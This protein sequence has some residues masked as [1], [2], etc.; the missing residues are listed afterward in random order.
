MVAISTDQDSGV[1]NFAEATAELRKEHNWTS[2]RVL[3][4]KV[5]D[6]KQPLSSMGLVDKRLFSGENRLHAKLDGVTTLWYFQYDNGGLP[7]ALKDQR[8]TSFTLLLKYA[9]EYFYKRNIE[10]TDVSN[11]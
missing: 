6:D 3:T 5:M 2:D 7:P 10:I 4:L 1:K 9:K 8:F 11:A